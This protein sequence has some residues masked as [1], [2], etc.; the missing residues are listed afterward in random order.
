MQ[1]TRSARLSPST[2]VRGFGVLV[3]GRNRD[4]SPAAIISAPSGAGFAKP[5]SCI[6]Q[7]FH[8]FLTELPARRRNQADA[9][10]QA[11][12][13]R[14][15][16]AIEANNPASRLDHQPRSG[17]VAFHRQT[18]THV[19]MGVGRALGDQEMAREAQP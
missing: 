11:F 19:H 18:A 6:A 5:L 9:V 12:R 1:T 2:L 17:E 3:P 16:R 4:P 14:Q 13:R 15:G 7:E 8:D 10:G